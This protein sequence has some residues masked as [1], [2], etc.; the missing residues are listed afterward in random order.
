M[1]TIHR[2]AV[3]FGAL[4]LVAGAGMRLAAQTTPEDTTRAPVVA[5]A[6]TTPPPPLT[7]AQKKAAQKAAQ[8][9][10][11]EA[12]RVEVEFENQSVDLANVYLR[13]RNG[14]TVRLGDVTGSSRRTLVLPRGTI[15]GPTEVELIAVP[16][17]TRRSPRSGSLTVL[18]GD[19]LT[20]TLPPQQ[21]MLWVLPGR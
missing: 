1:R 11:D 21:N 2:L 6:D 10:R 13:V 4:A 17:A 5:V 15:N 16:L 19:R 3:P 20:I 9:A 7:A 8:R 18:P 12:E 14:M